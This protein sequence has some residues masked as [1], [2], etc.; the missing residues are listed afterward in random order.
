MEEN[1]D[2]FGMLELMLRPG[3]CVKENK[4]EKVNAAAQYL[5][6][7]PGD[8]IRSLLLTG[9]EEYAA[10]DGGCLYL[11]LSLPPRSCGASVTRVD[12]WDI[13][14]LDPESDDG[15]LQALALAARTLRE[16]LSSVMIAANR[17]LPLVDQEAPHAGEQ[18]A[19]LNRSLH[20]ILRVLGN[21]S[22]A[23][24]YASGIWQET[25]DLGKLFAEILEKSQALLESAGVTLTY[26]GSSETI[27]GLADEEQLERAILN[28]LSNA[29]KFSPKGCAITASLTRHGRMLYFRVQDGGSGMPE[30]VLSSVFSRYLRQPGLEDSRYGL[31]LGM[32]L[33]RSAAANHGGAVLIDQPGGQGVRITMTLAIR[34]STDSTLRSPVLRP[35]YAGGR[36]HALIE[37]SDCLP[38]SAYEQE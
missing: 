13:F 3:F 29:V 35:D 31:G 15:P 32:V 23:G 26:Q 22:D 5:P 34:Q 36:D 8:D 17:L 33:V 37:L 10:F 12:G 20:Q 38:L 25:R 4:I 14:V 11:T 1:Q 21:M 28:L 7:V 27:L 30:S 19:Q 24:R 6:L 9:Q 16:P 18:A 2:I